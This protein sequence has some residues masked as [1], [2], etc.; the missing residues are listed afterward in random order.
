MGLDIGTKK[1]GIAM[2]Y[3]PLMIA[4]PHSVL[5]RT[6]IKQ[7]IN[8]INTLVVADNV[9]GIVVGLPVQMDGKLG[10]QAL[11]VQKITDEISQAVPVPIIYYDERFSSKLANVMLKDIY[12]KR[13][14]RNKID[15]SIAAYI[16]LD[17]FMKMLS[18]TTM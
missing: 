7:D 12:M 16:I 9:K 11:A 13:K 3:N 1:I 2:C 17:G 10:S 5:L 4:T 14:K 15:D 6:N 8:K 18:M